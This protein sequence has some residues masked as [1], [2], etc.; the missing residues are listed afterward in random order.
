MKKP[1]NTPAILFLKQKKIDFDAYQY[2]YEEKGGTKQTA[3][4]LDVD[5][6]AVIK[7]LVMSDDSGNIFLVLQHGDKEVSVKELAR[8]IGVKKAEPAN[9][10]DAQKATGYLFGGTS[11]FGTRKQLKVFAEKSI[12]DLD[13][14]YIN[15]GK[16]G[17]IVGISPDVL[18]K[19][20]DFE[21]VEAAN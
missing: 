16:Q 1:P 11:P 12:F 20:L 7:T 10:K 2:D 9:A 15:G 21:K 19:Y 13:I 4:E 3:E 5:E 17:L 14:I 6:H 18:E 8:Q